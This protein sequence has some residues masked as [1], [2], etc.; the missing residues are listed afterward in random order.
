MQRQGALVGGHHVH[1]ALERRLDVGGGRLGG[2]DVGVGR[3]EHHV[4]LGLLDEG[5]GVAP[6]V[7][8]GQLV[9][10]VARLE[11]LQGL[12][13]IDPVGVVDHALLHVGDAH[14]RPVQAVLVAERLVILQKQLG[15]PLAHR[16]ESDEQ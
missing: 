12:G 11:R 13:Q 3:L 14:H 4:R 1:A 9:E 8:L 10:G 15:Q 5:Q 16:P 7:G 6:H 2:L